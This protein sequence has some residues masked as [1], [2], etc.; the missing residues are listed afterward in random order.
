MFQGHFDLDTAIP[1]EPTA[2][3][4]VLFERG[5]YWASGRSG[6][7]NLV[8]AHK[9]FNLAALKG[10]VEALA[11]RREVADMMS[12]AEIA[13]AQREARAWMTAH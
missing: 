11:L 9:W 1:V 4:D 3:P 2:I 7:V 5:L 12:E 8:A 10:R 13:M 6:V